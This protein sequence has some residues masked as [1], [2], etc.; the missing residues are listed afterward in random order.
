MT[1]RAKMTSNVKIPSCKSVPLYPPAK[2]LRSINLSKCQK[3]VTAT[4]NVVCKKK[5]F[6]LLPLIFKMKIVKYVWLIKKFLH[7]KIVIKKKIQKAL[8]SSLLF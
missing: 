7:K 4:V 2:E 8:F 5:N 6:S 1:T 3:L